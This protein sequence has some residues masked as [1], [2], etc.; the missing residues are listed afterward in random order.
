MHVYFCNLRIRIPEPIGLQLGLL[1]HGQILLNIRLLLLNW[2]NMVIFLP[3]SSTYFELLWCL[4][5]ITLKSFICVKFAFFYNSFI[6][7]ITDF[8]LSENIKNVFMPNALKL[9]ILCSVDCRICCSVVFYLC[10]LMI[11][12]RNRQRETDDSLTKGPHC[13]VMGPLLHPRATC[14]SKTPLLSPLICTNLPSE[15]FKHCSALNTTADGAF[16]RCLSTWSN[17]L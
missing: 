12:F 1:R 14:S 16:W 3:P 4:I 11:L 10:P 6:A 17:I 2:E 9:W 8:F 15:F 5:K 13:T 7:Y